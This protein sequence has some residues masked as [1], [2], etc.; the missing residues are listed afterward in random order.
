MAGA[1]LGRCPLL[2]LLLAAAARSPLEK[3]EAER[4]EGAEGEPR[5]PRCSSARH[6][7]RIGELALATLTRPGAALR[8][9]SEARSVRLP[10]WPQAPVLWQAGC[11][12]HLRDRALPGVGGGPGAALLLGRGLSLEGACAASPGR[13]PSSPLGEGALSRWLQRA[14]WQGFVAPGL[15]LLPGHP[16][17]GKVGQCPGT[18]GMEFGLPGFHSW[19]MHCRLQ[20]GTMSCVSLDRMLASFLLSFLTDTYVWI[21]LPGTALPGDMQC[22]R[23]SRGNIVPSSKSPSGW[24]CPILTMPSPQAA[25]GKTECSFP[26]MGLLYKVQHNDACRLGCACLAGL[27]GCALRVPPRTLGG[28]MDT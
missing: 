25:R 20:A 16:C 19:V 24:P 14:L 15:G 4:T 7:R 17:L 22:V 26:E 10:Q 8:P 18:R 1:S 21:S 11:G 12:W 9:L 6:R 3:K 28:L 5:I 23:A 13:K 27:A 2:F